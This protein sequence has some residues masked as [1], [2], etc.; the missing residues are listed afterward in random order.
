MHP[1]IPLSTEADSLS[2]ACPPS[3][4]SS[5]SIGLLLLIHSIPNSLGAQIKHRRKLSLHL[6]IIFVFHYLFL[7]SFCV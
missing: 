2:S 4:A 5:I 1:N 6:K 3:P 7:K